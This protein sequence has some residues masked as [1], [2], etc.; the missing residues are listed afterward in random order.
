MGNETTL[1][2]LLAQI[3]LVGIFVWFT[4]KIISIFMSWLEKRD[5]Q[6]QAF[7]EEHRAAT[8][9]ELRGLTAEMVRMNSVL[10]A[11]DAKIGEG[12]KTTR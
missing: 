10:V 12:R 6:W 9:S 2:G 8:L 1:W 4:L 3:P 7:L 5:A 11:H